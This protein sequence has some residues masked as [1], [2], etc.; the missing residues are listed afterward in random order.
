LKKKI[1]DQTKIVGEKKDKIINF[2]ITW[3][4][5]HEAIL[6]SRENE[7]SEITWQ[8]YKSMTF[9]HM[10]SWNI[11]FKY[12]FSL[13]ISSLFYKICHFNLYWQVINETVRLANIV[14]GIFRK[15]LEDIQVKGKF[16]VFVTW[17]LFD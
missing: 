3:Q 8:E 10:V 14:P 13:W 16:I 9:T 12:S 6:R 5:E 4:K 7:E 1:L 17:V 11:R 2:L 15:A